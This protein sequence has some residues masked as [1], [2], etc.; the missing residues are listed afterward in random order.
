MAKKKSVAREEK[1]LE[2]ALSII[3]KAGLTTLSDEAAM[4]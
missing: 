1:R 4:S 2:E 3:A